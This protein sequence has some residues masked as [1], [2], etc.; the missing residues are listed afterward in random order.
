[1]AKKIL[2]HTQKALPDEDFVTDIQ[3]PLN[4]KVVNGLIVNAYDREKGVTVSWGY[5]MLQPTLSVS[6]FHAENKGLPEYLGR[7]VLI[8]GGSDMTAV[9]ALRDAFVNAIINEYITAALAKEENAENQSVFTQ[10][11]YEEKLATLKQYANS[12]FFA[13]GLR[14]RWYVMLG[15]NLKT[16]FGGQKIYGTS[17][18]LKVVSQKK[19]WN[20]EDLKAWYGKFKTDIASNPTATTPNY[21]E[22]FFNEPSNF[23]PSTYEKA[24]IYVKTTTVSADGKKNTSTSLVNAYTYFGNK[25]GYPDATWFKYVPITSNEYAFDAYRTAE[26][27]LGWFY[28]YVTY[29]KSQ[30]YWKNINWDKSNV[31]EMSVLFNSGRDI[32][33][34]DMPL[35]LNNNTKSIHF[36][37]IPLVQKEQVNSFVRLV[38]KNNGKANNPFYVKTYFFYET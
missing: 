29:V 14:Q 3:I 12:G 28:D 26:M 8:N 24:E 10:A 33:I 16:T 35:D 36:D 7:D 2:I 25:Y 21:W 11:Y 9:E 27:A 20:P 6:Q 37:L 38:F 19:A 32:A 13:M 15:V 22:T 30:A 1:M 18:P 17:E 23:D 4:A 5:D 34:R 31:G